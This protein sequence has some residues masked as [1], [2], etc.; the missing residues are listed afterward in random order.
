MQNF[1]G[2]N[3]LIFGGASG[4]GWATARTLLDHG[5]KVTIADV[6][7]PS[8]AIDEP[9]AYIECDVC[10]PQHVEGA[11]QKA[12]EHAPLDCL[13]YS[14]GVQHYGSV[15]STPVEEY[16]LVQQINV[17][18]AFLAC[19][20][21]IPKM[22]RG[23]SIVLVSSVQSLACQAGVAAYAAS[24]GAL[25]ALTRAMAIDHARDNIRVNAVLPGTVNTPMVRSSAE[26]FG[27]ADGLEQTLHR[28]GD[29]HPLGRVAEPPEIA[30]VIAFLLSE[31]ASFMTGASYRVDGGLLAQLGVRL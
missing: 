25:D 24:K 6:Q 11:V 5:A 10:N 4:I 15:V 23:G 17:R 18:G 21:A 27:G 2:E 12:I 8:E 26:L 14:A 19:K 9:F 29:N 13:V 20:A 16:D 30:N 7:Q 1:L 22:K 28:W 3:A 31:Q